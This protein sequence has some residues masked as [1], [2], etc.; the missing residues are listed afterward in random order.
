MKGDSR[1]I[2]ILRAPL[3]VKQKPI[4]TSS[5]PKAIDPRFEEYAGSLNPDLAA[6]SFSFIPKMQ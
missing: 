2:K 6:K 5:R 1:E 3:R 4:F